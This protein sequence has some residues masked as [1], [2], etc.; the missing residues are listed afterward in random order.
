MVKK[1]KPE[2]GTYFIKKSEIKLKNLKKYGLKNS[3]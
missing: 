2:N 3:P 1:I